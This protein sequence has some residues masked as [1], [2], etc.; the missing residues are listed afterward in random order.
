MRHDTE[1]QDAV[2]REVI[3][4]NS[5]E[6]FFRRRFREAART[7]IRE[8]KAVGAQPPLAFEQGVIYAASDHERKT[9]LTAAAWEEYLRRLGD[10]Q[11]K[12]EPKPQ[13][14]VEPKKRAPGRPRKA[15]AKET[16]SKP[17][18]GPGRPRKHPV[19][20]TARERQ[21]RIDAEARARVAAED[22]RQHPL[23]EKLACGE[24]PG[25]TAGYHRHQR[26]RQP[27]CDACRTAMTKYKT[28]RMKK[29]GG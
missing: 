13:P 3:S 1:L 5:V 7:A 29:N 22:E 25:T 11:P 8:A 6:V 15:P 21:D 28:E 20:E 19:K 24:K 9:D 26:A 4:D 27:A 18:R 14:K 10:P 17:K 2:I 23:A 16:A 12:V